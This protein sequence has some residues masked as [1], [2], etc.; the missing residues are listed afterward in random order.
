MAGDFVEAFKVVVDRGSIASGG[1][2]GECSSVVSS[3]PWSVEVGNISYVE[4]HVALEH[5][6]GRTAPVRKVE[7]NIL[8]LWFLKH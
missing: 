4:L 7:A 8:E 1:G 2:L 3:V 5:Q 6:V